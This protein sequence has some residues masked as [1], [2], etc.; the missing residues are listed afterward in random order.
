MEIVS[1]AH[2]LE[3]TSRQKRSSKNTFCV[4]GGVARYLT[5]Q[6]FFQRKQG[7]SFDFVCCV[8]IS[9]TA[10][11]SDL[12]FRLRP[13][14]R[15]R[16]SQKP[17]RSWSASIDWCRLVGTAPDIVGLVSSG[18]GPELVLRFGSTGRPPSNSPPPH[19]A[20]RELPEF[21]G[22]SNM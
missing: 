16:N 8:C 5:A 4:G 12:A 2:I 20:G 6:L 7:A 1:A 3:Q 17:V 21:Y 15:C 14:D 9:D 18:F 10:P 22:Y 13:L 19:L 11:E